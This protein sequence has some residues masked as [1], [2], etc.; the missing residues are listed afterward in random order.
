M[1]GDRLHIHLAHLEEAKPSE[2]P[3]EAHW[4]T[5]DCSQVRLCIALYTVVLFSSPFSIS[6]ACVS[7]PSARRVLSPTLI[8]L[9]LA[10]FCMYSL[11]VL[12]PVY[13]AYQS[14]FMCKFF[15]FFLPLVFC[16][17]A[18]IFPQLLI[19]KSFMV[20]L[21]GQWRFCPHWE[22]GVWTGGPRWG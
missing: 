20:L 2:M 14:P 5:P 1:K 16:R 10:G 12:S 15:L 4:R 7:P 3:V 22:T 9:L 18:F 19:I 8:S 17:H 11:C 6:D 13:R 21:Q